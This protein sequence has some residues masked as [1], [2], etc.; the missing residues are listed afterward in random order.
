[1]DDDRWKADNTVTGKQKAYESGKTAGKRARSVISNLDGV[2]ES[3]GDGNKRLEEK[4]LDSVRQRE[5]NN[6]LQDKDS[7]LRDN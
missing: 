1:M 3:E 2:L 6:K 7:T 5:L 4:S